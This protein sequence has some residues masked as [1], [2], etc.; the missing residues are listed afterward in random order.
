MGR[1]GATILDHGFNAGVEWL[2]KEMITWI[3]LH[4]AAGEGGIPGG[5]GA[6]ASGTSGGSGGGVGAVGAA[7]KM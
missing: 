6:S 3:T 7:A 2:E 1:T 4:A 5:N